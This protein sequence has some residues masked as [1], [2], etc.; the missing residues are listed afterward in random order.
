[1]AEPFGHGSIDVRSYLQGLDHQALVDLLVDCALADERF[2]ARLQMA[3]SVAMAGT[4]QVDV[5][6]N[7]IDEAFVVDDYVS[8]REMYDYAA[9]VDSVLDSLQDLLDDGHAGAVMTLTE[10]AIDCAEEAVGYVDDSDGRM[11][12]IAQRLQDLHH[13]ACVE[14]GPDPTAL[15][16]NLFDRERNSGD[17]DVFHA[18]AARYAEVLGPVGLAEYRR[19][20]HAEWDALPHL[21]PNERDRAWST[22]R[23]RMTR[24]ME[25]L[26]QLSGD[27]DAI[28]GV[29]AR[30]QS[31]AYQFVRIGEAL[32]EAGRYD[33]ALA[34]AEKGL[35]LHGGSDGR[36]V[37]LAA[38]EYHRAGR[39]DEAVRVAWEAYDQ[40]PSLRTYQ[41]LGD[42]ARRGGAW[43]AWHD[44]ALQL[45]RSRIRSDASHLHQ[46]ADEP[47]ARWRSPGPGNSTLVE[48]LLLDGDVEQAW[49]EANGAG[50]R[51]ELWLEL[52][53]RREDEHP[54]EAIP[55]WQ[56]EVERCIGA[57]NNQSYAEAVRLIA[58]IG[59]LMIAADH[60]ADFAVYIAALRSAHKPKRN[61]MKLFAERTW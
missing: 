41:Q 6:Q 18:S 46:R 34:W 48:V 12:D 43:A 19:V 54:L 57:K 51:R 28:V 26:A 17:L 10:H 25:T 56:D 52:A 38:D 8:Y 7:A 35:A 61:L 58:H 36:L 30:D 31:S 16:R 55:V 50:A 47:A 14:A 23:F 59:T 29:L 39:S 60:D 44:R 4:P 49:T 45:L 9:G 20:A 22:Q 24:I 15:A 33:D 42:Q 11:S 2:N 5:F 27:V 37:A 53:R 32:R 3:A 40:A 21:G 1:M 13:D